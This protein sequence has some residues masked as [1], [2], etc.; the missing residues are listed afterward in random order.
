MIMTP[1]GPNEL[2]PILQVL[3]VALFVSAQ[4]LL[5]DTPQSII[6]A[7]RLD[8]KTELLLPGATKMTAILK[9][10]P[11]LGRSHYGINE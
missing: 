4:L 11:D 10:E 6:E 2:S 9:R 8:V 7:H 5:T 1:L 3:P